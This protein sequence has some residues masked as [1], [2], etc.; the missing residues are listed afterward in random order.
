M[1]FI[2]IIEIFERV[3]SL[4]VTKIPRGVSILVHCVAVQSV[5][6]TFHQNDQS[7]LRANAITSLAS[8]IILF[9]FKI[10]ITFL[11]SCLSI[12]SILTYITKIKM[13]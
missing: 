8:S 5:Q 10:R 12:Y 11:E 7:Q 1:S 13:Q 3:C 4:I 2:M 6:R 9:G